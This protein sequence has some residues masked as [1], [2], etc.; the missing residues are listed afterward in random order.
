MDSRTL[1]EEWR[2]ELLPTVTLALDALL[3]VST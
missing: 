1:S 3:A 2:A